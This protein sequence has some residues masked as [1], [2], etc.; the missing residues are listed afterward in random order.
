MGKNV[1]GCPAGEIKP[2]PVR[3]KAEAGGGE[4]LA[5]LTREHGIEPFLESVQVQH[6]GSG[7]GDL[8]IGQRVGAPIGELLL[9]RDVD[10][11]HF[12]HEIL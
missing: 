1:L 3:Q 9:L 6:V 2:H 11:Q 10:S 7:V 4:V 12:A 8:C 5:P